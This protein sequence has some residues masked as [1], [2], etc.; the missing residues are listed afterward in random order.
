M[1][2]P[3]GNSGSLT[4]SSSAAASQTSAAD[5]VPKSFLQNKPLSVGVITAASIIGLILLI[6]LGTWAIR[7]RRNDRLDREI[8]DFST[9]NLVNGDDIEKA[10]AMEVGSNLGHGSGSSSG[11]GT[12]PP[13]VQSR[14]MY[15]ENYNAPVFP[16]RPPP[17]RNANPY[18]QP[19]YNA[20]GYTGYQST[21]AYNNNQWGYGYGNAAAPAQTEYDQAYAGYDDAYGGMA[22]A[23]AGA[24]GVGAMTGV[25]AGAQNTQAPQRRPSA[26]RKPPP[27][28]II[29]PTNPIA[30][31]LNAPSPVSTESITKPPLQPAAAP[32]VLPDEFGASPP[33]VEEP[34]RRLIV[35][36]FSS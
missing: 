1:T 18:G 15:Q 30:Q 17:S 13:P 23:G 33:A 7:K 2:L 36:L 11:H 28:L 12:L 9:S 26:N 14:Q 5:N 34:P 22:G 16:P 21:N 10:G 19:A 31:P 24:A 29:P 32:P 27:Q 8:L 4:S 25:G 35:R 20:T 3:P 6:V